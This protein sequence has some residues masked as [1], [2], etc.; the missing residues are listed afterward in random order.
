MVDHLFTKTYNIKTVSVDNMHAIAKAPC[1]KNLTTNWD[2]CEKEVEI[3]S[4]E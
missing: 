2:M 4:S 3:N 1:L